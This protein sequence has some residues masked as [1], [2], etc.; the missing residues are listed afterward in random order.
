MKNEIKN[1][2]LNIENVLAGLDDTHY[3]LGST[4]KLGTDI[5]QADGNWLP[6]IPAYEPQFKNGYDTYGCTVFGTLNA[7]EVL[8]KK[9]YSGDYDYAERF[10][11]II[12][13]IRPP[14]G[15]PHKVAEVIRKNGLIP[16]AL[17]P[18]PDTYEEFIQPDPMTPDLIDKGSDFLKDKNIGHEWIF[19]NTP[20]TTDRISL[21]RYALQRG[22]VCVSVTAWYQDSDG[23]YIDNGQGNTHWVC[24]VD[25]EE[26]DG[27]FYPIIF[28]SY[29]GNNPS[30]P[31]GYIKKLHPEHKI[32][33]AKRYS[34]T[35]KVI[36]VVN[37]KKTSIIQKILDFLKSLGINQ[38]QSDAIEQCIN[39]VL[40]PVVT[41]APLPVTP[42]LIPKYLWDTT[43]NIRHSLRVICDES[44][45]SVKDKNDMCAT[46]QAESGF[47]LTAVNLNISNGTSISTDIEHMNVEIEKVKQKGLRI[48]STDYGP[49]QWNDYYHGKEITPD[50]AVNNP[51]KA[52]RLMCAYWK[53]EQCNLWVAYSSGAYKRFL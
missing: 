34:I 45:L 7:F 1:Y 2:G 33:M 26:K 21:L 31:S 11:Y 29:E 28:D 48:S 14:G 53:R 37:Q 20:N 49:C 46:V 4:S 8:M 3:L 6:Y 24:L 38:K 5:L 23:L 18:L 27:K 40:T 39:P 47:K 35:P 36:P 25:I 44:G 16:Q 19:T 30:A 12:A 51:E 50:E 9:I 43:A 15:D 10:D 13:R 52:V 32:T 41:P 42:P 22:T 17:L